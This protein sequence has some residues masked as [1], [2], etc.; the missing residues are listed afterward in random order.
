MSAQVKLL[1]FGVLPS[2]DFG[3][4]ILSSLT[5]L[6]AIALLLA[7][8]LVPVTFQLLSTVG[9][10]VPSLTFIIYSLTKSLTAEIGSAE[11]SYTTC[12]PSPLNKPEASFNNWVFAL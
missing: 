5:S 4:V 3:R 6:A 8:K 2:S 10:I 7:S 11:E 12:T 9:V 1:T